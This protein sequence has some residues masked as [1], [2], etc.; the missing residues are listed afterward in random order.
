MA[1]KVIFEVI[2]T[3]QGFEIVQKQQEKLSKSVDKTTQ[4]HKK[5]DK[6]QKVTY[7][8]QEQGLVQTANGTKNFSKLASSIGN[9]RSGLV[10]AYAALAANIFAATA[11]FNALRSAAQVDTLIQGFSFLS[12]AA[13]TT[14][15]Q[16]AESLRNVTDNAISLEESL[17]ASSI[18]ITSG[19]NPE[20]IQRLG[21]VARNASIALGRNLGDS[22][23]RLFRGVAKL[24]PEILD[25]LGILVR[26]D[27]AT[28]E[29]GASIGKTSEELTDFER[30]QAFLNATITQGELKY[31]ALTDAIKPN[32]Y[33]QLSAAFQDLTRSGLK[34]INTVLTPFLNLL[35]GSGAALTGALVLFA[36]TILTQI[37]PA[38]GQLAQR[39]AEVAASAL[40]MA[41]AEAQANK[42]AA[43]RAKI[44]F[45]RGGGTGA[46]FTTVE[47]LKK[48][49]K[50]GKAETVDFEKALNKLK[51]AENSRQNNLDKFSGKI[52]QQKQQ[53]I[54]DIQALQAEI[55]ELQRLEQGRSAGAGTS[56][57]AFGR[58]QQQ[59]IVAAGVGDIT[60]KGIKE[61]FTIATA[62]FKEFRA[63]NAKTFDE[64]KGTLGGKTWS[65]FGANVKNG[66][67]IAGAGARLF[68]AALLNSI[69]II[70]QLLF[71]GGLL[72]Q[73]LTG[74][75]TKET[76]ADKALKA[77][78]ETATTSADKFKQLAETNA[79]VETRLL[80][81]GIEIDKNTVLTIQQG[82]A[83]KV[84]SGILQEFE[85]NMATYLNQMSAGEE[86]VGFFGA[87][88]NKL[89]FFFDALNERM[90]EAAKTFREQMGWLFSA[91]DFVADI[92]G[93]VADAIV[94]DE[95]E[96]KFDQAGI[97]L[98][99]QTEEL[100]E[101]VAKTSPELGKRLTDTLSNFEPKKIFTE[102]KNS[103]DPATGELYTFEK[104]SR[105]VRQEYTK[106]TTGIVSAS[107]AAGS[108]ATS[109]SE[110]NKEVAKNQKA[111]KRLNVFDDLETKLQGVL[112]KANTLKTSGEFTD[113]GEFLKQQLGDDPL[114][115]FGISFDQLVESVKD[116]E[117][118]VQNLIQDFVNA[119]DATRKNALEV[120]Q[121]NAELNQLKSSAALKDAAENFRISAEN[122]NQRGK[123]E[124]SAA[125]KTRANLD[126]QERALEL[127]KQTSNIKLQL[128]EKEFELELL[129]LKIFGATE[130]QLQQV[131]TV[132]KGIKDIRKQQIGDETT[133][134]ILGIVGNQLTA[135]GGAGADGSLVQRI[136][137]ISTVLTNAKSSIPA[138]VEA[139]RNA[140]S[141]M[142]DD[143]KKLGAEG[144]FAAAIGE[145]TLAIAD[146]FTLIANTSATAAEKIAA[147]GDIIST[148][149]SI[150]AANSKAN[151]AN[152]DQQI[153]A[154]K[155][156]DGK[157]AESLSKIQA[158]EKKKDALA[159][160]SFEQQKKIS[161][162]TALISGASAMV[163]ALAPPPVGAGPL[164]GPILA[165]A[166][167]ALTA[168][169]V[170]IISKQQYQGTTGGDISSPQTALSIGGRSSAVDISQRATS[171]E[172]SYLRGGKTT[173]EN[174][175]GS[176]ASL[177]GSAMGRRG[178]A[179]GAMLVGERGPEVVAPSGQVDVI[180]NY[181]LGGGSTNV[182]FTINAVDGQSV[183]N[184]LYTQRGNI[185]GMI[186]E[187]ANANGEGFL[188]SVD[189]AVYGG[190]G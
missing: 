97:N 182:N 92:F 107:D 61:S 142:F 96:R 63:E 29:Y 190:G 60:G 14:G 157:S 106:L 138:K 103:I 147:V 23:D 175:G 143:L 45:V 181:A 185:I 120:K 9:D 165:G 115:E 21:E 133:T 2:A 113:L 24:E 52:K 40:E 160:K 144:E 41:K 26:L 184:M 57:I 71:F 173:G 176:G 31:G 111:L 87:A 6:Q 37:I 169:Q 93:G 54:R 148:I 65:R 123:F 101:T 110:F 35:A 43:Q 84:T 105:L 13:G 34:L 171:G 129:K 77:L 58:A 44:S 170:A 102:L 64:L 56:S 136:E 122:F 70:G 166:I 30:R 100:I 16:V 108:I 132:I 88:L 128:L 32:A 50:S 62:S 118:P 39:Q 80:R 159:R 161:I 10:G 15:L 180:P 188:E 177:P 47:N 79:A 98:Q 186:R 174:L 141:P 116:G 153:E 94:G 55:I 154:E 76:A 91:A 99:K 126:K 27:T 83:L 150:M 11:A 164:F 104:A 90:K 146:S 168:A 119:A 158:L 25:E 7:G 89:T 48:K 82:N 67:S 12:N 145:G 167:A 124:I 17:R 42:E 151:I 5:L 125:D 66:F 112:D 156:R 33:D 163:A 28:K 4:S 36:S 95:R 127:E 149:G 78:N 19:F 59:T 51:A 73:F 152:L 139:I 49:L 3:S 130:E 140:L 53:E 18:A 121:L 189:P 69:P 68:G 22:L 179:D 20:Q 38:F 162:A 1:N 109:F 72:I 131:E 114:K 74:L 183:Q 155:R 75:V 134:N 8:R 178:Y 172:L 135:L 81:A 86:S 187:A 117:G 46:E 85:G 137:D